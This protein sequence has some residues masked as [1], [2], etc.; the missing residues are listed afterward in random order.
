MKSMTSPRVKIYDGLERQ[1]PARYCSGRAR[2]VAGG[3]EPNTQRYNVARSKVDRLK[4]AE[5]PNGSCQVIHHGGSVEIRFVDPMDDLWKMVRVETWPDAEGV[6]IEV[7]EEGQVT[8]TLSV[9]NDPARAMAA[10]VLL[11]DL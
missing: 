2:S 6:K 11:L 8:Q 3:S 9:R 5:K 1:G 4:A 10:A 7:I